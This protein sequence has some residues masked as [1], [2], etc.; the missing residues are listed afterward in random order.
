MR[1][2]LTLTECILA[3]GEFVCAALVSVLAGI[4]G[5]SIHTHS[6]GLGGGGELEH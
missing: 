2:D 3:V 4:V 1:N 5:W 6:T